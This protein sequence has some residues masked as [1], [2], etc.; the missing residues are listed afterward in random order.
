MKR[1]LIILIDEWAIE[2]LFHRYHDDMQALKQEQQK[3]QIDFITFYKRQ[4][5][6]DKLY[7]QAMTLVFT[8]KE[9]SFGELMTVENFIKEQ[10]RGSLIPYDGTGYYIDFNGNELGYVNW[11]NFYKYPAEAVFVAWYNK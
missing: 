7:T 3:Q 6:L 2:M 11:N 1:G 10:Q 8:K 4:E 9:L 5:E